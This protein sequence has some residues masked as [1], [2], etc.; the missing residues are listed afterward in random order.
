MNR[1]EY[2]KCRI[3]NLVFGKLTSLRTQIRDRFPKRHSHS[4]PALE[5]QL[6]TKM[7]RDYRVWEE[8]A[9]STENTDQIELAWKLTKL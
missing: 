7:I 1:E 8:I 5:A 4:W 2:T 9:R 6:I 3:E